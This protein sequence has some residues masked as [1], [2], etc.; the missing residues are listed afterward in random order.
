MDEA[1]LQA[2][3]A[4]LM[5][6]ARSG[7]AFISADGVPLAGT[8]RGLALATTPE[9]EGAIRSTGERQPRPLSGARLL[10]CLETDEWLLIEEREADSPETA[11]VIAR[12]AE[13]A[14]RRFLHDVMNAATQGKL[15]LVFSREELP[16]VLPER[17]ETPLR[18]DIALSSFR[19]A[20]REAAQEAGVP[21]DRSYGAAL[22]AGEVAMNAVIHGGGGRAR[23]GAAPETPGG[24]TVQ[25]WVEDS[26]PGIALEE[27]PQSALI[28]GYS[29]KDSMG[30]GFFLTLQEA[31]RV[32][33]LTGPG[34]TTVVVEV[35]SKPT[36]PLWLLRAGM[37]LTN[38]V[39]IQ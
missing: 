35:D 38:H 39:D 13:L 19:N 5:E 3:L 21:E 29:T 12:E 36:P 20:V 28:A 24:G 27:L 10:P 18:S 15:K 26:G 22:A 32:F 11:G 4:T 25:I 37:E 23:V 1:I 16:L 33:L 34:G 30:M 31:D 2:R 8:A 14:R 17:A 6:N 9:V 7:L